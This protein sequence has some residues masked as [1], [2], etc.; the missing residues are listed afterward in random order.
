[1]ARVIEIPKN[2]PRPWNVFTPNGFVDAFTT[3][4]MAESFARAASANSEQVYGVFHQTPTGQLRRCSEFKGG[5]RMP[6]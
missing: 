5:R 1:M 4:P 2:A 6:R 3:E